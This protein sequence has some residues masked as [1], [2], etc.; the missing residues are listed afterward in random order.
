MRLSIVTTSKGYVDHPVGTFIASLESV[1]ATAVLSMEEHSNRSHLLQL[2]IT[3]HSFNSSSKFYPADYLRLQKS[4]PNCFSKLV[5]RIIKFSKLK[6]LRWKSCQQQSSP[7]LQ[8]THSTT[9]ITTGIYSDLFTEIMY[10]CYY[11]YNYYYI[12]FSSHFSNFN[13]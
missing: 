7:R 4:K 10:Q 13:S 2:R 12:I 11:Y 3:M 8:L 9:G 5:H 6:F 1:V